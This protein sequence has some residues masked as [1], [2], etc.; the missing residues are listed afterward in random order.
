MASAFEIA[1]PAALTDYLDRLE[2]VGGESALRQAAVAGA[3]VIF[4]EV[5]LRAPA[6]TSSARKGQAHAAGTLRD[7][8]LIAYDREAS[9]DGH[10][11]MYLVTWSKEAF[12]GR[13]VEF[14]TSKMAAQPFLRPGY[15]A[16][17]GEAAR[18]M[19]DVI[20]KLARE[21]ARGQ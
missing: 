9:V 7:A 15:E 18:A 11:A 1:N 12:Y 19:M 3:R 6:G 17:K 5:K 10:L 8:M 21:A 14:G 16:K 13:F 2:T 20:E 4:N